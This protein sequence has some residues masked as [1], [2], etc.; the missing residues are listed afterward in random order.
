MRIEKHTRS[1]KHRDSTQHA[2][3]IIFNTRQLHWY[4]VVNEVSLQVPNLTKI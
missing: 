3:D 2:I 1:Q 4:D